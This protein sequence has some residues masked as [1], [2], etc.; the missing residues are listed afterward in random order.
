MG[1]FF[2]PPRPARGEKHFGRRYSFLIFV[3]LA[4][5]TGCTAGYVITRQAP[6]GSP[7][8]R[9]ESAL[10][11]RLWHGAPP[12]FE[13]ELGQCGGQAALRSKGG[14]AHP[15]VTQGGSEAGPPGKSRPAVSVWK[16]HSGGAPLSDLSDTFV[17]NSC[18]SLSCGRL[19][20]GHS[21][22]LSRRTFECTFVGHSCWTLLWVMLLWDTLVGIPSAKL[23]QCAGSTCAKHQ[24]A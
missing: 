3:G 17:A 15:A 23:G 22:D 11:K 1:H 9:P 20:V 21:R 18:A 12:L 16:T 2:L 19:F 8:T 6:Q 10:P 13:R 14:Q 7:T 5:S 24:V 4:G